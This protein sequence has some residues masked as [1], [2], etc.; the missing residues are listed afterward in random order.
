MITPS[1]WQTARRTALVA[2][3]SH[4]P[5][6]EADLL[7]GHAQRQQPT[8]GRLVAAVEIDCELLTL[9]R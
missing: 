2:Q 7:L 1:R 6:D 3:R 9:D 4:E 8:V 5:H